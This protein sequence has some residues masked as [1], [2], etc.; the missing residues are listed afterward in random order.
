MRGNKLRENSG[1]LGIGEME[2]TGRR[3]MERREGLV[4]A[5]LHQS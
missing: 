5:T 2:K 3:G 4:S 1:W